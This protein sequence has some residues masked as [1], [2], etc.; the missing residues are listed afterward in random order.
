[1]I[2]MPPAQRSTARTIGFA[3]F[4]LAATPGEAQTLPALTCNLESQHL[5]ISAPGSWLGFEKGNS[6][7]LTFTDIDLGR[8]T[9]RVAQNPAAGEIRVVRGEAT[10]TFVEVT[11]EG[12]IVATT[13][14]T[15]DAIFPDHSLNAAHSRHVVAADHEM[16]VAQYIGF[17]ERGS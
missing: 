4:L 2:S 13:V 1:M 5:T 7:T 12:G 16:I 3:A 8:Q 15:G 10:L 11:R 6:I 9:A 14:I 17:C